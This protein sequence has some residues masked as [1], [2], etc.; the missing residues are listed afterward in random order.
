MHVP[1]HTIY[2]RVP[3]V[4]LLGIRYSAVSVSQHVILDVFLGNPSRSDCMLEG[5]LASTAQTPH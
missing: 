2:V 4:P 1:M 5:M 3:I